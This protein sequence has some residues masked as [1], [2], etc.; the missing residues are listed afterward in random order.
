MSIKFNISRLGLR[1]N[2]DLFK[3]L[4][5]N[6]S[7]NQFFFGVKE[8]I[9]IRNSSGKG[10]NQRVIFLDYDATLF[11]EMLVPELKYLQDKYGLSDFVVLK[12]SQKPN[13]FHA[14]CFDNVSVSTWKDVVEESSC[15]E[16]YKKPSLK[17]FR[18]SVLRIS[19]KGSSD[20][21]TFF[22]IVKSPFNN[23]VKSNAHF[24]FFVSNYGIPLERKGRFDDSNSV[25]L[26]EYTTL[27]YLKKTKVV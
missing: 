27:N 7:F 23:F 17:D 21:P 6:F 9:G 20:A 14:V 2:A 22:S 16:N 8:T 15:D 26:V 19:P 5:V 12:S 4:K 25:L 11:E 13:C 10:M 1:F 18:T 3:K 24:N